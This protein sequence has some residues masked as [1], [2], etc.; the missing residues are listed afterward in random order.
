[1]ML[2]SS[3]MG[4]VIHPN[5]IVVAG[6]HRV[7]AWST[8]VLPFE[9]KGWA[10]QLRG[11]LQTAIR[12][13]LPP[14]AGLSAT[15]WCADGTTDLENALLY[16]VGTN[17]F[18]AATGR[19]LLRRRRTGA[20]SLPVPLRGPLVSV[21]EYRTEA[22]GPEPRAP[23]VELRC[24]LPEIASPAS[25]RPEDVWRAVH[26]GSYAATG[27]PLPHALALDVTVDGAH[28]IATPAGVVKPLVDGLLAALHRYS[29]PKMRAVVERMQLTS[30]EE[31]RV[32]LVNDDM[33]FLGDRNFVWPWRSSLQW[34]P[35][36]ER[37]TEIS[38]RVS[39]QTPGAL[40]ALLSAG[41]TR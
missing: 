30:A 2:P 41:P 24:L 40:R 6:P 37:L 14:G 1:M 5:F 31:A 11:A 22:P 15:W 10:L 4:P 39:H 17:M 13:M 38:L 3:P 26:L 7:T 25:L 19:L 21:V 23:L 18:A 32:W 8:K 9:P 16:N 29:G 35:A 12:A 20:P 33:R 36:D 34:S 27:D 28:A